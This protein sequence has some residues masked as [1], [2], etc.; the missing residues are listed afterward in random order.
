MGA[1]SGP[2]CWEIFLSKQEAVEETPSRRDKM[3][4]SIETH[5]RRNYVKLITDVCVKFGTCVL[6]LWQFFIT[7]FENDP[8]VFEGKELFWLLLATAPPVLLDVSVFWSSLL[9]T[10]AVAKAFHSQFLFVCCLEFC[11]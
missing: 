10:G 6:F 7:L 2:S 1:T 4:K 5:Q 11:A 3:A 9:D 8:L